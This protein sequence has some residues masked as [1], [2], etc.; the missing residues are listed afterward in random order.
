MAPLTI[1]QRPQGGL[2][3]PFLDYPRGSVRALPSDCAGGASWICF[4]LRR[5]QGAAL[6]P[7]LGWK[8]VLSDGSSGEYVGAVLVFE[9]VGIVCSCSEATTCKFGALL[10]RAG[11]T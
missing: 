5:G 8:L 7:V 6:L 4:V 1:P 2:R 9:V 11:R 10:W 3:A